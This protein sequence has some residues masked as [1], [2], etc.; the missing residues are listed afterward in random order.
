MVYRAS[1]RRLRLAAALLR[2]GVLRLAD[3]HH[4]TT[5]TERVLAAVALGDLAGHDTVDLCSPLVLEHGRVTRNEPVRMF[6]KASSTLLASRADASMKERLF[7]PMMVSMLAHDQVKSTP[8]DVLANCLAS[9]VGTARRCRK[10]LLFPTSMITMLESAWSRS[11]F[12][13]R[14]TLS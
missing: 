14:L 9:S 7:S 1:S 10:S 4:L 11:S 8:P 2:L 5:L 6:W 3:L 13:H 12:S